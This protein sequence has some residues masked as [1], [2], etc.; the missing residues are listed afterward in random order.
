MLLGLAALG[1]SLATPPTRTRGEP[2]ISPKETLVNPK[3]TLPET[4]YVTLVQSSEHGSVFW[5]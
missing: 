5:K 2:K 3:D 1:Y 4:E